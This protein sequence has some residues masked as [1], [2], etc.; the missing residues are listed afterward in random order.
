V[1]D[2]SESGASGSIQPL[3]PLY[4]VVSDHVNALRKPNR[5]VPAARLA[6]GHRCRRGHGE[7]ARG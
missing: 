5:A 7:L 4:V 1:A 2:Q 3:T 6:K